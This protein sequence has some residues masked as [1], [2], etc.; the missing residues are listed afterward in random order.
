MRVLRLAVFGIVG[1]GVVL[2]GLALAIGWRPFSSAAAP[3]LPAA[4]AAEIA[5][6]SAPEPTLSAD[7]RA[8]VETMNT[9][10]ESMVQATRTLRQL[11]QEIRATAAWKGKVTAAA[12]IITGGQKVI[13]QAA[14]PSR[15]G[16]LKA[17]AKATTDACGAAVTGLPGVDSLTIA[18]VAHISPQLETCERDLKRLQLSLSGL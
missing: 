16:P 4:P 6:T 13:Q 3:A 1:L 9:R 10:A 18:A 15:Y 5:P 11:G 7:E 2:V 14:L 8:V 12:G 17:T